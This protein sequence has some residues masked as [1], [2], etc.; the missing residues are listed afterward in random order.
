MAVPR[1]TGLFNDHLV[2]D[3][4]GPEVGDLWPAIIREIVVLPQPEGPTRQQ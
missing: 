3:M 2:A 1:C 4:D